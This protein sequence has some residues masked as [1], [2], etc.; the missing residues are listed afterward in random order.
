MHGKEK[1]KGYK[2]GLSYYSGAKKL[3]ADAVNKWASKLA[4]AAHD[5]ITHKQLEAELAKLEIMLRDDSDVPQTRKRRRAQLSKQSIDHNTA[6]H[7]LFGH[8]RPERLKELSDNG[9]VHGLTIYGNGQTH[10]CEGCA[11][12][13]AKKAKF[14]RSTSSRCTQRGGRIFSDLKKITEKT[15]DKMKWA[16]CFIDDSCRYSRTYYLKKKSD[17]WRAFRRFIEEECEPQGVTVLRLRV[18]GG[19]EY[20]KTGVC[21]TESS[22]FK[23]YLRSKPQGV[24]IKVERS[25]A[26]CQSMNGV[27]ERYWQP[28]FNLVRSI[29]HDQKRDRRMWCYASDLAQLIHNVECTTAVPGTTPYIAWHGKKPDIASPKWIKPLA[30]VWA[31]V[32][33]D[34]GRTTLDKVRRK[35][36]FVGYSTDSPCYRLFNPETKKVVERRYADC[37]FNKRD[38][39][40]RDDGS[41]SANPLGSDTVW[42]D[43]ATS[44]QLLA[45]VRETKRDATSE[46]T[47]EGAESESDSRVEVKL[48]RNSRKSRK[49]R[50][51]HNV[52][53]YAHRVMTEHALRVSGTEHC[54]NAQEG[55]IPVPRGIRQAQSE[56]FKKHWHK[57]ILTE[58]NGCWEAD[59]FEWTKL[60]DLPAAAVVMDLVWQFK[61]KPDRLKA[62]CCANGKQESSSDYEDIYSPVCKLT[63][64]RM[65]LWQCVVNGWSL[66]SSDVTMAYL[67]SKN[68]KNQYCNAPPNLGKPGH[69]L[70]LKRMLY[71]LH[72]SGLKWNELITKWLVS[73]TQKSEGENRNAAR[74]KKRRRRTTSGA[75]C[76]TP[77]GAVDADDE[78]DGTGAGMTQSV[79]DKCLFKMEKNG[80]RMYAVLYVDDLLYAGDEDLID[81]FK[82]RLSAR[83]KVRHMDAANYL[84]LDIDY[85]KANGKIKISQRKYTRQILARFGM[86]DCTTRATPMCGNF[87]KK[88]KKMEGPCD[89]KKRQL[90]YRQICGSLNFLSVSSRPDISFATKELSRH[91]NHPTE[92]HVQ[93]G[94]RV[95]RYL[96]GTMDYGLEYTRDARAVFYG[97]ADADFAGEEAT[98]KS[99]S[100]FAFSGGSGVLCWKAATQPIVTHSSTE[101]ELVA[102]DSAARE[103]EYLR[104]VARDFDINIETPVT[105]YQDNLSTVRIAEQGRFSPRTKHLSVRYHY[106][107]NLVKDGVVKLVHLGTKFLPSDALTK[108]LGPADHERH[109]KVLLGMT[110]IEGV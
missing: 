10:F 62:R 108:A 56:P 5:A 65:L 29:L 30:D 78:G 50:K 103:L 7:E 88:L 31:Y 52:A 41:S 23:D 12:T 81:E 79:A 36:V 93:A 109:S 4:A 67:Y 102:L 47:E 24:K 60:S 26:Y 74:P 68:K 37:H 2:Y 33:K 71:G 107:H 51:M 87:R 19:T 64:M 8:E 63:T 3:N 70:R 53:Q 96:K 106:T 110:A 28:L 69:V 27:S 38:V 14:K 90:L 22:N 34:M 58:W 83:F 73:P 43:S 17:A 95:L 80:K 72:A 99:T 97:H 35:Y 86:L 55:V 105:I 25:P 57:P 48:N 59:C 40:Q 16:I 101:A 77:G 44:K 100:G 11:E 85:D 15:Y 104:Q 42:Y 98:A 94:L 1:N 82:S 39:Q 84:G 61:V 45:G 76:T 46:A 18:D 75:D 91:L 54:F 92:A 21:Y 20:G 6:M 89:D 9:Y 66:G 13:R 49:R 32:Y